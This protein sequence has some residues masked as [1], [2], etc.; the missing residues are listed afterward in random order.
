MLT[1]LDHGSRIDGATVATL[2]AS[3][4]AVADVAVTVASRIANAPAVAVLWARLKVLLLFSHL[5]PTR[6]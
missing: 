4:A 5:C 1:V 3:S 2:R 6:K